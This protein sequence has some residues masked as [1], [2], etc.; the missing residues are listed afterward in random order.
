M[1]TVKNNPRDGSD[2]GLQE[3]DDSADP[4]WSWRS[5]DSLCS[6]YSD[7]AKDCKK[8]IGFL[9]YAETS[10]PKSGETRTPLDCLKLAHD[11][12]S[13]KHFKKLQRRVC[14]RDMRS[15]LCAL[16]ARPLV[17]TS[18]LSNKICVCRI[19]STIFF[20]WSTRRA[21]CFDCSCLLNSS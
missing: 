18:Q 7:I 4:S 14:A 5:T 20:G 19:Y 15:S 10:K 6:K 17:K 9:K 3:F 13:A 2:K 1:L 11:S 8:F 12:F 21:G 16:E